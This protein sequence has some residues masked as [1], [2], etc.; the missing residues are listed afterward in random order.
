M[1]FED[2]LSNEHCKLTE[3]DLNNCSLTDRC[4]PSLCTALKDECCKLTVLS[5]WGNHITDCGACMLFEDVL[6]NEH[7]KLTELDLTANLG[8][9]FLSRV[10]HLIANFLIT[11]AI[12]KKLLANFLRNIAIFHSRLNVPHFLLEVPHFLLEVPRV[13]TSC[14][15]A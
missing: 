12:L 11:F 3:L 15:K 13:L 2:A 5:L 7:W 4:I 14:V 9:A 8:Q 1:L 6:S 10:P